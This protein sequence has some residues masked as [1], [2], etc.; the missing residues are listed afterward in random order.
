MP[1]VIVAAAIPV[2]AQ[3]APRVDRK[4][5]PMN[6]AVALVGYGTRVVPKVPF[7]VGRLSND[8]DDLVFVHHSSPPRKVLLAPSDKGMGM[9]LGSGTVAAEDVFAV[10]DEVAKTRGWRLESAGYSVPMLPGLSAWS[11]KDG[12]KWTVELTVEGGNDQDEMIYV[13]GPFAKGGAPELDALVAKDMRV[14]AK[15]KESVEVTYSVADAAWRQRRQLVRLKPDALL[16]I[17][18]QASDARAAKVFALADQLA[19]ETKA[20]T[21]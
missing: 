4:V 6:R 20:A 16:L 14:A 15:T 18:A 9:K 11:T 5:E 12:T 3:S 21:H 19:R 10:V 17:T 2:L 7:E 13:E 8:A 1:A